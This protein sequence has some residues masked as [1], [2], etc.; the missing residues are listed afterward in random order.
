LQTFSVAPDL[1]PRLLTGTNR[2]MSITPP[3]RFPTVANR[4]T[5]ISFMLLPL[6]LMHAHGFAEVAI[7]IADIGFLAHS[8]ALRDWSWLRTPWLWIA[9]AWW[10]W[11][12][13]CSLP[14]GTVGLGEGGVRSLTQ[15]LATVR[16]LLLV[17]AM[18]H[19]LPPA[20]QARRWLFSLVAASSAWIVLNCLVQ[21]VFG[22]NLIGW[23]R[24]SEGE[25]TG[26]FGAPRAGPALVR[27]L[28][29]SVLPPAA[30]LLTRPGWQPRVYAYALLL[31]SLVVMVLIGQRMPLVLMVLGLIIVAILIRRLR[32]AILATAL[33]GALLLAASPVVAP[34]AYYRLIEKFSNQLEHFAVS[35]YGQLYTRAWEIGRQNPVTGMGFDGFGTGCPQA[36]YFRP[37]FDDS[38]PDG[39][40]AAICWDHPHNFY[41]QALTD[42]GFIGLA[43]FC[44]TGFAWLMPLARGLWRDPD[45]LR[46]GLFAA[47]FIQLWPIQ[48]STAFTSMPIGGWFFL[49]LGW[50]MAEARARSAERSGE[51][52]QL[53]SQ[54]AVGLLSLRTRW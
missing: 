16:F 40:G 32:P 43:L 35:P 10:G 15:A 23:P 50:G 2:R 13:I 3:P 28:L 19:L 27:I 51:L 54:P 7:G 30:A 46:V 34:S 31:L 45:P 22:R 29:P 12:I 52:A 37:T 41:L 53:Q 9:A 26:P 18:E 24:S 17:A 21:D 49:L 38:Q 42:G 6:L 48:S 4:V 25:L 36:R 20:P 11:L 47:T 39:G 33:V 14:I 1:S 8:A 5:L 44:A